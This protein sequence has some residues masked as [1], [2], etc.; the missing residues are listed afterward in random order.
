MFKFPVGLRPKRFHP[1][2]S[3][4]TNRHISVECG[5]VEDLE[6]AYLAAK[7]WLLNR[8]KYMG[9]ACGDANKIVFECTVG[10]ATV[11]YGFHDWNFSVGESYSAGV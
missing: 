9:I 8:F 4:V 5:G 11:C 7:E 10:K 3:I 1:Y 6:C 2:P